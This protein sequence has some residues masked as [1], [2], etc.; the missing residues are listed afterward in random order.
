MKIKRFIK[1]LWKE[2]NPNIAWSE[3]IF[4]T[5]G[6]LSFTAVIIGVSAGIAWILCNI[7]HRPFTNEAIEAGTCILVLIWAISIGINKLRKIWKN[8]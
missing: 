1:N 6:L 5:I 3:W 2:I 4:L 8:S 7:L